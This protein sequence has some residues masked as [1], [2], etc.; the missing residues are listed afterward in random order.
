MAQYLCCCE[1]VC[2]KLVAKCSAT[3]A[4]LP[5]VAQLVQHHS[6]LSHV[7][8]FVVAASMTESG[9]CALFLPV[10]QRDV[11]SAALLAT[12]GHVH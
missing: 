1:P 2:C 3:G 7:A 6:K 8:V 10:F 12:C 4:Q 9:I 5:N 11:G